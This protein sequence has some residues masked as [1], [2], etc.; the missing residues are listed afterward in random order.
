VV[1]AAWPFLFRLRGASRPRPVPVKL[2]QVVRRRGRSNKPATMLMTC[3]SSAF[4]KPAADTRS[5]APPILRP[6]SGTG[7]TAATR[8][9][10]SPGSS[11]RSPGSTVH[12]P[13]L[14]ASPPHYQRAR[15]R[16]TP[17]TPR[18]WPGTPTHAL[19][20]TMTALPATL[21]GHGVHF[22]TRY[23]AGV[24]TLHVPCAPRLTRHDASAASGVSR[25]ARVEGPPQ[26]KPPL[27][28]PTLVCQPLSPPSNK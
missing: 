18:S 25:C 8:T 15:R 19:P 3:P 28:R 22:L 20:S 6:R 11:R 5:A 4:W 2:T 7:S 9:G 23:V 27:P 17:P 16:R 24:C 12:R 21:D 1:V 10:W 13:A 26:V 14:P